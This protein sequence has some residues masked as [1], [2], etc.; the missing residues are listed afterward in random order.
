MLAP[1]PGAKKHRSRR[2]KLNKSSRT[3]TV[4]QNRK[5][6][7]QAST[8]KQFEHRIEKMIQA[9]EL[10]LPKLFDDAAIEAFSKSQR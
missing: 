9:N 1:R 8:V 5:Q 3:K 2:A 7:K 10:L 6:D 4:R